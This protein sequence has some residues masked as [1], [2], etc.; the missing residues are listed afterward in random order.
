MRFSSGKMVG[1][2]GFEPAVSRPVLSESFGKTQ[3]PGFFYP[4]NSD[5][6][7]ISFFTR[8]S[9][10]YFL[11]PERESSIEWSPAIQPRSP[12]VG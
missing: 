2:P 1:T 6:C 11:D 3:N 8:F 9:P 10:G 12:E 4:T 5:D 7:G